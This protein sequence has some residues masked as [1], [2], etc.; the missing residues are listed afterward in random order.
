MRQEEH[1]S[2]FFVWRTFCV[3]ITF[4][5]LLS[6]TILTSQFPVRT[7]AIDLRSAKSPSTVG[8]KIMNFCRCS[9]VGLLEGSIRRGGASLRMLVRLNLINNSQSPSPSASQPISLPAPQPPSPSAS[10]PL[11]HPAP[12]PPSPLVSQPPSSSVSQP[13]SLP[14]S[15]PPSSS[16]S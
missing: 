2:F 10:Q 11:S 9:V 15:Q 6:S 7:F 8:P 1:F 13:L 16:A 12:Q 5:F 3:Q 4:E 14:A